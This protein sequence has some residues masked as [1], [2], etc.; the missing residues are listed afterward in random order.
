MPDHIGNLYAFLILSGGVFGYYKSGSVPSLAAGIAF[1]IL[2]LVSAHYAA[3]QYHLPML[4]VLIVRCFPEEAD[5]TEPCIASLLL[6]KDCSSSSD[7]EPKTWKLVSKYYSVDLLLHTARQTEIDNFT[8]PPIHAEAVILHCNLAYDSQSYKLVWKALESG[9]VGVRLLV[10]SNILDDHVDSVE[11][12]CIENNF[13]F[14]VLNPDEEMRQE[15]ES[16]GEAVGIDRLVEVL[17]A[18]EWRNM[19]PKSEQSKVTCKNVESSSDVA[20]DV[21]ESVT[22]ASDSF[23]ALRL[24]EDSEEMSFSALYQKFSEMKEYAASLPEAER[25]IYAAHVATQFLK[26]LTDDDEASEEETS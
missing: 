5:S 22:A 1:G 7:A 3:A 26:I 14:I 21:V 16:F 17:Q 15:A 8:P 25:K 24:D 13:D 19:I 9:D 10:V 12:W 11:S 6:S 2:S 20:V 23:Q 18:N 4:H